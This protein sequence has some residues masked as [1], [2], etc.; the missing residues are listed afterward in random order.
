MDAQRHV[1]DIE[2]LDSEFG[3]SKD[4]FSN[5]MESARKNGKIGQTQGEYGEF[6]SS[7]GMT[8]FQRP[9]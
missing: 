5:N 3:D 1:V 9:Y 2:M 4:M 7:P 6:P 8:K